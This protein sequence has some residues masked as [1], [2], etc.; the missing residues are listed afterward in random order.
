MGLALLASTRVLVVWSQNALRSDYVR[1]ELLI[2]TERNKKIAA[3][4][5][6]GAPTFPLEGIPVMCDPPSLRSFLRVW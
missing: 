3:Y 2:A 6:P 5:A 4:I 1:A